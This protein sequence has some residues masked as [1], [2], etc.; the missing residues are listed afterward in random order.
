M[1]LRP[2]PAKN[3]NS[4]LRILISSAAVLVASVMFASDC[5]ATTANQF[6]Q[7]NV[8]ST[9]GTPVKIVT[10][11]FNHDGKADVV[12]LN[13][14]NVLSILLGNG[15]STFAASKTIATLPANT[16]GL[17]ARMV[18]GDFNGDGNQDVVVLPSGGNFVRVFLGHGDGTFAA[19]VSISAGLT[20]GDMVVGDF[21]GDDKADVVVANGTSIS[22]LLGKS[23]GTLQTAIVTK[24]GLSSPTSLVL[25][26]GDVNRDSHLDIA[27]NDTSGETQV[28]L[29][30]GTG[31]FSLKSAFS[32]NPPPENLPTTIAIADFTGDGKP[33]IA[34]G[35]ITDYPIFYLG[36]ACITPG[37]GDGTFNQNAVT[38]ARTPYTFGE[39]HAGNL[40]GK[41][42]LVFSSDPMMVQFNNGTGVMTP[43]N[44][45]VGGGP[46]VLGDFTGDG[47]QD[48][49]VGAVGGVQVVVNSAPG[50]FARHSPCMTLQAARSPRR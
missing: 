48:I 13:S 39:M 14:N 9:G 45:G 49:A 7:L 21:N 15:N 3:L 31:H 1:P 2:Y 8:Y 37:Y 26:V 47:R 11:D 22:V 16:A 4:Y 25:A 6:F 27:A 46:M 38:C 5:Y 30:T 24:T 35:F 23:G 20:A 50:F 44:Y 36:Q 33:D 10:A 42:D 19:P 18:A 17:A 41:Q 40:N 12:A 29:G 43:S 32:F 28:L 34:V